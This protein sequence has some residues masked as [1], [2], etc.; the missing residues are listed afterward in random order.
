[1]IFVEM[2][3]HPRFMPGPENGYSIIFSLMSPASRGTVRLAGADPAD[4]PIID[5]GYLTEPSDVARMIAGL[6]LA[7]EVGQ[8][9]AFAAKRDAEIFPGQDIDTDDEIHEYLQ[10]TI[11]SY[12]HPVG[13]CRMGSDDLSVVDPELRGPRHRK[14]ADCRC[15]RD[16]HP[17]VGQH[18]RRGAGGG[19]AGGRSHSPRSARRTLKVGPQRERRPVNR[20][21][22]STS[23]R[24]IGS[25]R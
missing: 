15:F 16:A 2:A 12:F 11:T 23:H 8:A 19:R 14:P 18:Q 5:P 3:L 7:R 22:T 10:H 20:R 24:Q 1:M 6:R 9:S 13:T 4:A 21:A 17:H 25:P